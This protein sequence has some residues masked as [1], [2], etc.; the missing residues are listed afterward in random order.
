MKFRLFGKKKVGN[1]T[2]D[3]KDLL[4]AIDPLVRV[5]DYPRI[6]NTKCKACHCVYRST[7]KDLN[8]PSAKEG[9]TYSS[10]SPYVTT[11][12]PICNWIN[13]AEFED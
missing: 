2:S 6:K 10:T 5:T 13:K 4:Q 9:L 12:C 7:Y 11:R 8:V 1:T 3:I